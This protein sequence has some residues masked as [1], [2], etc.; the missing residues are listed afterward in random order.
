[1]DLPCTVCKGEKVIHSPGFV[2]VD[3]EVFP[4]RTYSCRSCNG[5]GSFPPVDEGKVMARILATQGKNKGKLRSSMTSSFSDR[6]EARAYYVWRLARFHG[7]KDV[8]MPV[9]ADLG[10][11]GDPFKDVLDRLADV[12][13]RQSFGTDMAAALRWGR[14]LGAF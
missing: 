5:E 10:V 2:G 8:T 1:M 9:T 7:G 11:R 6:D 3:G 13:A 4:D 12:V 14:A